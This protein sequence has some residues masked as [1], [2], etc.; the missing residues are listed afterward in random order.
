MSY[1]G[2]AGPT[3]PTGPTGPVGAGSSSR[4]LIR[5]LPTSGALRPIAD[6]KTAFI[7]GVALGAVIG[8][9]VALLLAP[10]S[11][12]ATRRKLARNYRGYRKSL[13]R[14]EASSL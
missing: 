14:R 11:G 10:S 3:G 2:P 8:A 12:R 5:R 6:R 4:A 1:A 7:T 13:R 9:G